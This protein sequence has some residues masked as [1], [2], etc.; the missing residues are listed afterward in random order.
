MPFRL[1]LNLRYP[2]EMPLVVIV[3]EKGKSRRGEYELV[4]GHE[5][6]ANG[7]LLWRRALVDMDIAFRLQL[8]SGSRHSD[9]VG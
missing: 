3:G 7:C 8:H 4:S 6:H 1:Q 9:I 2:S 5:S